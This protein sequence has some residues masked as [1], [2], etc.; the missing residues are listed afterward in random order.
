[1]LH[2]DPEGGIMF[3]YLCLYVSASVRACVCVH[4]CGAYVC[5]VCVYICLHVYARVC[6]CV[7]KWLFVCMST[8]IPV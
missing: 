7:C 5:A 2:P 3:V 6:L 8:H 4:V 1:M